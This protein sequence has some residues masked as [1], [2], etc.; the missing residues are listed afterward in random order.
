MGERAGGGSWGCIWKLFHPATAPGRMGGDVVL[1]V[2]E[3]KPLAVVAAMCNGDCCELLYTDVELV[4]IA[5]RVIGRGVAWLY[6]EDDVV[7][8]GVAV[9]E[10][11]G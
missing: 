2:S 10:G 1:D 6:G 8:V 3:A 5:D 11:V 7:E 4:N 9:V